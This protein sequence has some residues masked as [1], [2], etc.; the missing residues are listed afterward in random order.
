MGIGV[1]SFIR[2]FRK[3]NHF[4]NF[5]NSLLTTLTEPLI[6]LIILILVKVTVKTSAKWI[7]LTSQVTKGAS[8]EASY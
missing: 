6:S 5:K 7:F 8:G 2:I 3:G 4:Y 1:F